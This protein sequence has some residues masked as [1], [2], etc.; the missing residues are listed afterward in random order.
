MNLS[1]SAQVLVLPTQSLVAWISIKNKANQIIII[2]CPFSAVQGIKYSE[3]QA[4]LGKQGENRAKKGNPNSS[5]SPFPPGRPDTQDRHK[6]SSR[7]KAVTK[8]VSV[9]ITVPWKCQCIVCQ[10]STHSASSIGYLVDSPI[11]VYSPI[12][13]VAHTLL[14]KDKLFLSVGLKY[15]KS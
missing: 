13:H 10:F 3:N 15:I 1:C 8:G 14:L 11:F 4:I 12:E 6:A 9:T 7:V 2:I 5:P